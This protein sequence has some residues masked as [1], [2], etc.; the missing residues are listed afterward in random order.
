MPVSLE[1]R[2]PGEA[3]LIAEMT[4][5]LRRK[6]AADHARGHTLRDL[7]AYPGGASTGFIA[8]VG[9]AGFSNNAALLG[10]STQQAAEFHQGA[11][12]VA[13]ATASEELQAIFP[14]PL[15]SLGDDG[16]AKSFV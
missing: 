11:I 8:D 2:E 1:V 6:M 9:S 14:C 15:E 5:I 13:A 12:E 4:A 10:V 3:A 16:C 7:V